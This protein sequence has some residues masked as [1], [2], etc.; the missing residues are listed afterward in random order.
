V[1][2]ISC[3]VVGLL[4]VSAC[5]GG[6]EASD[7]ADP[8][9]GP[10][11]PAL[12]IPF[13]KY[14]LTP[15]GLIRTNSE[16]GT[17]NGIERPV[18]RTTSGGYLSRDFVFEVDVTIPESHGDIAYVGFGAGETN[19]S[20][21]NEPSRAFLFRIHNL[22]RMPFYGI[23][24]TVAD[25][26]GGVGFRGAYREF[27]R[28]GEYTPGKTMRFRIAYQDGKVTLSV[29][30]LPGAH[31]TFEFAKFRDLFDEASAYL[32]LANSSEGTTFQNAS[33]REP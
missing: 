6:T 17:E 12:V 9:T 20:L 13:D 10:V 4:A 28:I 7:F 25:P 31:A 27:Q 22:P 18:V 16:S 32:F 2:K 8:L 15:N 29:P 5:A 24:L 1:L 21:D 33:L 3:A 26:N 19:G 14:A 30:A 11:S 23:D